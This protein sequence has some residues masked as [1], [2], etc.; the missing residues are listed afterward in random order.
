MD[1]SIISEMMF[2]GAPIVWIAAF[3][4]TAYMFNRKGYGSL[5][6]LVP[7][8][9]FGPLALLV[10]LLMPIDQDGREEMRKEKERNARKGVEHMIR[11]GLLRRC[12]H[13]DEAIQPKDVSCVHCGK[14]VEPIAGLPS[15][16][17]DTRA[18]LS[19]VSGILLVFCPIILALVK[20]DDLGLVLAGGA[21]VGFIGL[22]TTNF[23][24]KSGHMPQ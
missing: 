17:T 16:P 3:A 4:A 6:M 22:V 5:W 19:T 20:S 14:Q 23:P 8:F 13:C 15:K 24:G 9:I 7:A 18:L 11:Y 1:A 21:L 12:P 2:C 10:S